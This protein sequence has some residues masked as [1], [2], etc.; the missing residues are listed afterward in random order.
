MKLP[1]KV[2]V[3][4]K[5]YDVI[6][7]TY[8]WAHNNERD[9]ENCQE[10]HTI[11]INTETSTAE[12]GVTLFHELLHL[13]YYNYNIKDEDDEERTVESLARGMAQLWRDNPEIIKSLDKCWKKGS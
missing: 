2:I 12:V 11:T 7:E 9:G 6:S 1:D 5:E 3:G 10:Y 13:L 8:R 4:F